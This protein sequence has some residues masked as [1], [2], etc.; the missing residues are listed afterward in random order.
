MTQEYKVGGVPHNAFDIDADGLYLYIAVKNSSNQPQILK[1]LAD[2]S[3]NA[4]V[5]YNPGGGTEVN[6]DAGRF[7]SYFV[8]ASGDFGG[9]AKVVQTED[10][11]NYWYVKNPAEW[12]GVAR[13]ILVGPGSDTLVSTSTG[14]NLHQTYNFEDDVLWVTDASLLSPLYA[15]ERISDNV[16]ELTVGAYWYSDL[17]QTVHYSP[18][19]GTSFED[20]TKLLPNDVTITTIIS[21]RQEEANGD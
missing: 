17:A 5:S 11:G 13:P 1:M 9:T 18:N 2:L 3:A 14:L 19:E 15:I 6:L 4:V 16:D 20:I 8:W 21:G 12:T 10:G 7:T